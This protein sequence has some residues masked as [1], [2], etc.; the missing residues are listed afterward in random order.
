MHQLKVFFGLMQKLGNV[1][2]SEMFRAFNMG[3]GMIVV[4]A[5]DDKESLKNHFGTCF[6]IGRV[7]D[8]SKEVTII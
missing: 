2:E 3:I 8:G 1:E 7:I 6:E 5:E 4:C